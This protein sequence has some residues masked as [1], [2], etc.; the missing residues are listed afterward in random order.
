[1]LAKKSEG[2]SGAGI[3]A[4]IDSTMKQ[5]GVSQLVSFDNGKYKIEDSSQIIPLNDAQFLFCLDDALKK[6]D[7]KKRSRNYC[8]HGFSAPGMTL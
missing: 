2:L 5:F 6:I 7:G 3:K 1:M 8:N 4:F